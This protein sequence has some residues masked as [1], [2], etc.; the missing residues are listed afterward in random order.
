MLEAD[1]KAAAYKRSSW[2]NEEAVLGNVVAV[3]MKG[4]EKRTNNTN[5]HTTYLTPKPPVC[6]FYLKTG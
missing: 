6:K 3:D 4:D 2:T 1:E 5:S